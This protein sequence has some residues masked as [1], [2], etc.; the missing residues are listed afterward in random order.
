V[1][2]FAQKGLGLAGAGS[3]GFYDPGSTA[4]GPGLLFRRAQRCERH[5]FARRGLLRPAAGAAQGA[6]LAGRRARPDGENLG[7]FV[8]VMVYEVL[9]QTRSNS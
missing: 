4:G 7:Q 2:V 8:E 9:A 5:V 3:V 6:D 1:A